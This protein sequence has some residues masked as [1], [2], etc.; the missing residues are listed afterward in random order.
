[1]K[2]ARI[3]TFFSYIFILQRNNKKKIITIDYDF[4]FEKKFQK[5]LKF[6]KFI[7]Y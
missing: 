1:M 4:E 2:K 5:L 3:F 7:K 6:L